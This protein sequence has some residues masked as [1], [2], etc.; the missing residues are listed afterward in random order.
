MSV[1]SSMSKGGASRNVICCLGIFF[2]N[3]LMICA[4][5]CAVWKGVLCRPDLVTLAL[6]VIEVIRT[7]SLLLSG[8]G[9]I[10][11]WASSNV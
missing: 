4:C 3:V 11:L 6:L 7:W 5:F 10:F 8:S 9:C 1:V 2:V